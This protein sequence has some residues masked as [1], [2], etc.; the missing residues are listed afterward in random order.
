[1]NIARLLKTAINTFGKDHQLGKIVEE[2]SE[3]GAAYFHYCDQ[4]EGALDE[5]RSELADLMITTWQG[6]LI[7][8]AKEVDALIDAKLAKL[9][10]QIRA[11]K[12]RQLMEAS[13]D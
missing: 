6:R 8:G 4:R 11:E 10:S 3:F 13:H 9:E 12:D 1:M 2:S 5:L 7:L